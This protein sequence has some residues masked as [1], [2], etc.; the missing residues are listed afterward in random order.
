MTKR[1]TD[2]TDSWSDQYKDPRW[3][4]MRLKILDRDNYTC[5]RCG[6]KEN[7]LHVHHTYYQKG[8][9]IFDASPWHLVTL[10]SDCHDAIHKLTDDLKMY[11]M[12]TCVNNYKYPNRGYITLDDLA[13]INQIIEVLDGDH[14]AYRMLF[15]AIDTFKYENETYD[16]GGS[17]EV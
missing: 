8:A 9:M 13:Y 12:T 16:E 17:D 11:A 2:S 5:I 6:D 3:Q 15:L 14:P 1:K 4:K 10:C 7:Q